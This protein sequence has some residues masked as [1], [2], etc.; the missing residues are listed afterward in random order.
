M[1]MGKVV[2]KVRGRRKWKVS[3]LLLLLL[4]RAAAGD[5]VV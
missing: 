4:L 5:S 1:V 2:G 3:C